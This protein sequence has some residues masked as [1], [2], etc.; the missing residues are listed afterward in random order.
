MIE[1]VT[2][3]REMVWPIF[4]KMMWRLRYSK[5]YGLN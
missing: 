4:T 2:I 1:L 5:D 3:L